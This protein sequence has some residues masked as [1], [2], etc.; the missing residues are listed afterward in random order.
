MDPRGLGR[1]RKGQSP[2][3][4][5]T[6][7]GTHPQTRPRAQPPH[8]P[9]EGPHR[10]A[11]RSASC[12]MDVPFTHQEPAPLGAQETPTLPPLSP[13]KSFG[14]GRTATAGN[15]LTNAVHPSRLRP[16]S[17][18]VSSPPARGICGRPSPGHQYPHRGPTTLAGMSIPML[19]RSVFEQHAYLALD[20][21][22]AHEALPH[23]NRVGPGGP[24]T[25]HICPRVN[26]TFRHQ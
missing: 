24:N 26:A 23:Q 9:A 5:R 14:P 16:D 21:G 10:P 15:W 13:V 25:L 6:N 18:P 11:P 19:V 2:H 4:L 17:G 20:I 3:A 12:R 8:Q 1:I 7:A 22:A